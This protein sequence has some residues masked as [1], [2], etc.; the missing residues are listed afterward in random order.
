MM[1][2]VVIMSLAVFACKGLVQ[3]L[4]FPAPNFN[5][6][7]NYQGCCPVPY[8]GTI[9]EKLYVFDRKLPM[10]TRPAAHLLDDA[11]IAKYQRAYRLLRALPDS[12]PRSWKNQ[13]KLHC[14]YCNAA[15]NFDVLT[16]SG[17]NSTMRFEVHFGWMFLPWHRFFL[18][19]HE[20]ILAKLLGD[21]DTFA[22]PFWNWDNQSPDPPLANAIPLAFA[23]PI[24]DNKVQSSLYDERR[25]RCTKWPNLIDL[26]N[27]LECANQTLEL[28]TSL[29][30]WNNRLMYTQLV[31]AAPISRLFFGESYKLGSAPGRGAGTLEVSPHGNV[32]LW[33]GNPNATIPF[34]DM[35]ILQYAALDP[36]FYAHHANIDRL[37]EVWK[38]LPG[39]NRKDL[40]QADYLNTQF[41]FYDENAA[42][43]KVQIS[44]ALNINNF[45]YNYEDVPNSWI[46]EGSD[47]ASAT[48]FPASTSEINEMIL[49]T[50]P[51]S[52]KNFTTFANSSITFR[53]RRPLE[54][55]LHRE[56]VL[57]IR[58][59]KLEKPL[60]PFLNAFLYFPTANP[61]TPIS[62]I[63]FC[64]KHGGLGIEFSLDLPVSKM[65]WRLALGYKLQSLGMDQFSHV[66][67]TLVQV[68]L[69][70]II[71]LKNAEIVYFD[72]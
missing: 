7:N 51:L 21:D 41:L 55:Q 18:Y 23:N 33:T 50:P 48:C 29:R 26:Q 17:R 30:Q 20:R 56:E 67:V 71:Q 44:Q 6:C 9:S 70:Q 14:A 39:G 58:S 57:V 46:H 49:N 36:I 65:E 53:V 5:N 45:R 42:L 47:A 15:F 66:V 28:Q 62:C 60:G 13:A 68:E 52:T 3:A 38:S 12:D 25:N 31:T 4:P 64:G 2:L 69:A 11:Y 63:E 10:R 8:N 37:W 22:L 35:G 32:H 24:Y 27:A 40:S 43:V 54:K 59:I 16:S 72:E 61:T 19:F 1:M 34:S